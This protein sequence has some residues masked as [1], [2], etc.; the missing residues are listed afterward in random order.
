MRVRKQ[1]RPKIN[2][3]K[4]D[5]PSIHKIKNNFSRTEYNLF[6]C[7]HVLSTEYPKIQYANCFDSG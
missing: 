6:Y 1:N 7:S 4:G 5:I 3:Y 2:V